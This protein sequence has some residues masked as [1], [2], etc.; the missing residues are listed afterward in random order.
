MEDFLS[1]PEGKTIEFKRDLS[2]P[3]NLLKNFGSFCQYGGW[4][5]NYWG[6]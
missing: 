6:G 2:S 4:S 1:L 5:G 3:K